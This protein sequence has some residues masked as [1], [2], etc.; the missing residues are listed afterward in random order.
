ML[1]I[2]TCMIFVVSIGK[3]NYDSVMFGNGKSSGNTVEAIR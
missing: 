2:V 1:V 3:M